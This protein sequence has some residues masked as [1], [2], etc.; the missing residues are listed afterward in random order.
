MLYNICPDGRKSSGAEKQEAFLNIPQDSPPCLSFPEL[1]LYKRGGGFS[2]PIGLHKTFMPPNFLQHMNFNTNMDTEVI[3]TG[4]E[5][6]RPNS[7]KFYSSPTL[8]YLYHFHFGGYKSFILAFG[9]LWYK[10]CVFEVN[11]GFIM[12]NCHWICSIISAIR[13]IMS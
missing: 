12:R 6:G 1:V 5:R 13:F 2:S 9:S 10:Y 4:E 7:N 11:M 8:Q 3:K